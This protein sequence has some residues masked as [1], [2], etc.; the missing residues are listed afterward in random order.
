MG[1]AS[2]SCYGAF[3]MQARPRQSRVQ[4]L[5]QIGFAAKQMRHARD[6]GQKT[7]RAIRGNHGGIA[8]GPAAQGHQ[9][10]RLTRQISGADG[11]I[12]TDRAGIGQCHAAMQAAGRGGGVQAMQMIGI[13]RAQAQGKGP[14]NR[15]VPQ[16][17]V[18]AQ[19]RKPD[20]QQPS[21]HSSSQSNFRKFP[22]C[23]Y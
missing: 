15:A 16:A 22:F 1:C 20:G 7:V 8:A 21:R 6:I 13:A 12:G 3:R 14:F 19:P 10:R 4:V 9:R 23:S 5:A 2:G 11:K 17:D 18:A